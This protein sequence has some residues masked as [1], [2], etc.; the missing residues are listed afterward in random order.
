[1]ARYKGSK[2]GTSR[3]KPPATVLGAIPRP[4]S[5][6]AASSRSAG[7]WLAYLSGRISTQTEVP[8]RLLGIRLAGNGAVWIW[9]P[10]QR[11]VAC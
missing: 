1:M 8:R 11:Q 6:Q 7:R 10:A 5:S 3:C 4:R 9:R 2:S